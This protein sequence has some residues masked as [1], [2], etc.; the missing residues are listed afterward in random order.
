[1][2]NEQVRIVERLAMMLFSTTDVKEIVE[3]KTLINR[4]VEMLDGN[5]FLSTNTRQRIEI[6]VSNLFA[7]AVFEAVHKEEEK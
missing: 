1:M 6:D 2:S 3:R 7:E 4:A 5:G